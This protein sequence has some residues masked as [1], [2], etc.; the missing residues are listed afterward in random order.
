MEKSAARRAKK[1]AVGAREEADAAVVQHLSESQGDLGTTAITPPAPPS[2][3]QLTPGVRVRVRGLPSPV[4]LQRL[5]PGEAAG[6][7]ASFAEVQAGPLRMKVALA[8]I[9]ALADNDSA[10]S[11]AGARPSGPSRRP[12]DR[13]PRAMSRGGISLHTSASGEASAEDE[14]NV[15]GCTVEEATSR[16]DKFLDDAALRNS[17]R[18]RIIHGHGTG[19]LRR[20]LAQFLTGHPH[21]ER[22]TDEAPER[23]GRAVTLVELKS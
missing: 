3:D 21:V 13:L 4:T 23:G 16:V 9:T 10:A 14:I 1:V 15:I 18:V 19:A 22:F 11:H 12:H 6:L 7:D 17:P 5:V 20:G 2:P 8:D